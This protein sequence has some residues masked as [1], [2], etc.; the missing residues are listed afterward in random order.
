LNVE[1]VSIWFFDAARSLIRCADLFERSKNVH[2]NG[3]ELLKRDFPDYFLAL[4]SERTIDAN[5]AHADQRTREFS[6][7]YLRPCGIGAM[8]DAPIR[9]GGEM[10]GVVCHEHVGF[11]RTWST[12]EMA[13]GGSMADLVSLGQ[14]IRDR[15]LAE[16]ALKR[17]VIARAKQDRLAALGEMSAVVAHEVRNPIG[18]IYNTV[19][20]LRRIV[21]SSEEV[22]PL[23]A[24]LEEESQRLME[25]TENL[26]DVA[27]PTIAESHYC[28][29]QPI[30]H[31]ALDTLR[32]QPRYADRELLFDTRA[33][34]VDLTVYADVNLLH[35]VCVNLLT[36]A[37]EAADEGGVVTI[38]TRIPDDGW[39]EIAVS[40]QGEAL[41]PDE[42]ERIFEPFVTT[43][44]VGSGLGLAIVR[45]L[46]STLQG[47]VEVGCDG[48]T[49]TFSIFIPTTATPE[50]SSPVLDQ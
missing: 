1:R 9:I 44:A 5:D 40:N 23:L 8:L 17:E 41:R 19:S 31:R 43:K 45:S 32:R 28:E 34:A 29:L 39:L 7:C 10:V 36:N 49:I 24:V 6:E 12:G 42:V 4:E 50:T 14:E 3:V 33:I 37:V 2:S 15:T 27:R 35:R 22:L 26:L 47:R 38:A 46:M 16:A 20:C 30:L 18:A 11:A 48:E 13:F 25:L 21:G